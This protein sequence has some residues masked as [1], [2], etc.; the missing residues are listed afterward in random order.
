MSLTAGQLAALLAAWLDGSRD[1]ELPLA[2]ALEE[3]GQEHAALAVRG[4]EVIRRS[5]QFQCEED[6]EHQ[7][8]V[9]VTIKP[10]KV[11]QEALRRHAWALTREQRPRISRLLNKCVIVTMRPHPQPQAAAQS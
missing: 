4:G 2:D 8:A 7:V 10:C 1:A 11:A 6:P 9:L 5:Y 3:M